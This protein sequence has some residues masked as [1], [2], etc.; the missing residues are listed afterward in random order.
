MSQ[1]TVSRALREMKG[2]SVV[3]SIVYL[4]IL[5]GLHVTYVVGAAKQ[6]ENHG[7]VGHLWAGAP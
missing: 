2:Q 3:L 5:S 6:I 7:R 1:K 4:V